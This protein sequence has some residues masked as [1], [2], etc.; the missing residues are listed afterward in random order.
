M[1]LY[2]GPTSGIKVW[3][4]INGFISRAN[5]RHLWLQVDKTLQAKLEML[6]KRRKG[7]NTT[8]HP[9]MH[10]EHSKTNYSKNY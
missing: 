5:I 6:K 10:I 8:Y 4:Q 7:R 9:E 3:L 2:P 1:D